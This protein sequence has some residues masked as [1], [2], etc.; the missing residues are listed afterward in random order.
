MN[1]QPPLYVFAFA[2]VLLAAA[3]ATSRT[4]LPVKTLGEP[5]YYHSYRRDRPPEGAVI[6]HL[7]VRA[8]ATTHFWLEER[9]LGPLLDAMTTLLDS[10][11]WTRRLDSLPRPAD[12]GPRVYVGSLEGEGAPSTDSAWRA[13]LELPVMIVQADEP[14]GRWRDGLRRIAAARR[15]DH[16]LVVQVG[17][18]EYIVTQLRPGLSAPWGVELG[19]DHVANMGKSFFRAKQAQVLHFTGALLAADGRVLRVGAEGVVAQK[20]NFLLSL[21]DVRS[22]VSDEDVGTLLADHRREDLPGRPLVWQV[23]LQNLVAQLLR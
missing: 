15:V 20:P 22:A 17:L 8:D 10:A 9:S 6:A 11:G 13:H 4:I 23:A 2:P 1:R 3:C 12:E 19:T 14:T 7:P 21:F 5:P 16:L 18:S